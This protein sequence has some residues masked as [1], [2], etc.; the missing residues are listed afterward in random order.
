MTARTYANAQ[1]TALSAACGNSDTVLTVDDAS[2]FPSTGQFT[3]ILDYGNTSEEVATVTAK[4]VNILTVLRGQD[5][6]TAF[7]HS[8]GAPVVHGIS[9]RDPRE[10][11]AHVN[12]TSNVHGVTGAIVG[13]SDTQ[14]L[15]NK[16]LS[17]PQINSGQADGLILRPAAG[18]NPLT[19]QTTAGVT[20][21]NINP[22]GSLGA[23]G[24]FLTDDGGT[25]PTMRIT[26]SAAQT[27]NVLEVNT[28]TGTRILTIGPDGQLYAPNL[29]GGVNTNRALASLREKNDTQSIGLAAWETMSGIAATYT[30][31]D[32]L[33]SNGVWTFPVNGLYDL[34]ATVF[35]EGAA[36]PVG[37]RGLRWWYNGTTDAGQT[38]VT[39]TTLAGALNVS[40]TI[41]AAA[42]ATI[43]CQAWQE[44]DGGMNF[45]VGGGGSNARFALKYVG[46]TS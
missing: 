7:T 9:A 40:S 32:W 22:N 28:S 46:P 25:T 27:Q 5:S 16:T 8:G 24:I 39:P 14:T 34:S 3:I 42:G 29:N 35:Y 11:N 44:Q 23:S 20:V 33:Y 17:A 31:G 37:R 30:V 21:G 13:D 43:V 18:V 45:G 19:V 36:T 4:N 10:A 38:L 1:A 41:L 6:T 15:S 26:E 2:S 12:A